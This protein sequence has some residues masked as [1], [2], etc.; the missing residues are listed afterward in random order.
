MS[1]STRPATLDEVVAQS[2]E[3][4]TVPG[5]ALGI[6]HD[7]QQSLHA[8]GLAN[9]ETGYPM[10]E[11]TILQ[12]GSI[13]KIFTTTLLMMLVDEGL[14]ALDD[15]V[16]KH[17]PGFR[18]TKDG[19]Q[20]D[21]KIVNLVN[22]T[23]GVYGDHFEDFGWGDDALERYVES[24][25]ELRQ[26]Y[27]PGTLWSYTNSAFNLAGRIIE[28]KLGTTF[29]Q[30]MK[31]RV[32]EP[33]GMSRTFYFPHEAIAYPVSVGHTLV[34]P[35]GDEHEVAR[36]WPIPRAS[37]PA[38]SISSTVGDMLKFARFH[39][40]D[41]TWEG[42]RL[43]SEES[44]KLM[45]EVHVEHTGMADA[46]GLG[47]M[48]NF[49][50]GEKVIGH[51][52]ATNGFNAHLDIVP[53]RDFALVI[54][55]NSDRGAAAYREIIDWVLED[56]L[57]L[58]KQAAP[59]VPLEAEQLAEYAG[60]YSELLVDITISVE[61]DGLR[62][63]SIRKGA[64]ADTDEERKQP[65]VH[66]EPLGN[67]RFRVTNGATAGSIVDFFRHADGSIRFVRV[68]GRVIGRIPPAQAGN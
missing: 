50:D 59:V 40:G 9:L 17:L 65:P 49:Y 2:M 18:L 22:H 23:S 68:G 53:A 46:W 38:G 63:D 15:P 12:I 55:T 5:I 26:V 35:A 52:G 33:L 67:D 21:V 48:I 8:H 27:E 1:T 28:L 25:S 62:L 42:R 10:R 64:L 4:W 60:D 29:E 34:D 54:L 45:Q 43:L 3:R 14:I 32:F 39:M 13:S 7:G 19:T 36:R 66:L 24:M 20:N 31:E 30:A 58:K 37:G 11:D 57:G 51:G 6:W 44:I 16:S 56:R 47:W 61:G 41:G